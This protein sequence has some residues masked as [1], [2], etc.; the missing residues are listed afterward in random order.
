MITLETMPV[1]EQPTK[2]QNQALHEPTSAPPGGPGT[3]MGWRL[4][5]ERLTLAGWA[6]LFAVF[7][8]PV[9]VLGLI[10][11]GLAQWIFGWCLGVWCW[12]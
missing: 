10:L 11:D 8:L 3:V 12:F 4:G 7:G 5:G 6:V 9:L 2:A 1:T